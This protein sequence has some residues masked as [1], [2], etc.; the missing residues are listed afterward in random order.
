ML[1]FDLCHV[2]EVICNADNVDLWGILC[3]ALKST[4]IFHTLEATGPFTMFAATNDAFASLGDTAIN[5][6]SRSPK[7]LQNLMS[8]HIAPLALPFDALTCNLNTEM[9]NFDITYTL[10]IDGMKFQAGDGNEAQNLPTIGDLKN[11]IQTKNGIIHA[12]NNLIL[13][14]EFSIDDII[15]E[16]V[17]HN[18]PFLDSNDVDEDYS[19]LNNTTKE[20]RD[21]IIP[22]EASD[23]YIL[24]LIHIS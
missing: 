16:V 17:T 20:S 3:A 23:N 11:D 19:N 14:I 13:P 4:N 5:V 12:I 15:E 10:C 18:I 21:D 6:L 9:L 8:I 2:A 7:E 1:Y 22:F 24:S